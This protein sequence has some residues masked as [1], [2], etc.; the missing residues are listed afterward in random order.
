VLCYPAIV[1][2]IKQ[3]PPSRDVPRRLPHRL[4]HHRATV[5]GPSPAGSA[6]GTLIVDPQSPRPVIHVLAYRRDEFLEREVAD[7]QE[8]RRILDTWSVVWVNV[9]GLGDIG[10]IQ[11]IGEVFRVHRLALEDVVNRHQRSKMEQYGEHHFIV[12]HMV[13]WHDQHLV[14][15][16]LSMFL[17][18]NFVL[19]FQERPGGDCFGQVRERI[20]NRIGVLRDSAVDYLAYSLLDAVIDHYFP[21]LELYGERLEQLEDKI[22]LHP[23]QSLIAEIHDVKRELLYLRRLIWPQR[24]MIN[25]LVRD[26]IP[27]ITAETRIHLRDCYDHSIRIIDLVETYRELSSDLMDLYLSSLSQRMNEIMKVLAVISTIFMPLTFIAGVYGMNFD[28]MPELRW[29]WG[30]P[31][32]LIVM[33]LVSLA[34]LVFFR[35]KG[36]L[37]GS[38]VGRSERLALAQP[39]AHDQ[40]T[41]A[42]GDLSP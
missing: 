4:K 27:L 26:P 20:R 17:G 5:H 9:D 37:G 42:G 36:W 32:S 11:R 18:E 23:V 16:Q 28:V 29:K 34:L 3:H 1:R 14:S 19:T 33:L 6:P 40:R 38:G 41:H 25:S 22:V 8:L 30:Y 21:L 13:E 12:T 2:S 24:E 31:A 39:E 7:P 10:L 15:E 35:R